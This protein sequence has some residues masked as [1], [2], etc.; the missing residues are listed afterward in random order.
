MKKVEYIMSRSFA[1][2]KTPAKASFLLT[3]KEDQQ[4]RKKQD[5]GFRI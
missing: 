5:L 3:L 4:G 1:G 2:E